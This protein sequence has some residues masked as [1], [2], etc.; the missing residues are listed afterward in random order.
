MLYA[1]FCQSEYFCI[2][3]SSAARCL[4][5]V[6]LFSFLVT[7]IW[8]E[9]IFHYTQTS[10]MYN[11]LHTLICTI[12]ASIRSA[13]L[14]LWLSAEWSIAFKGA[15]WDRDVCAV[16]LGT[17]SPLRWRNSGRT[18]D[19]PCLHFDWPWVTY[20]SPHSY[21]TTFIDCRKSLSC[22]TWRHLCNPG[23][24]AVGLCVFVE[25]VRSWRKERLKIVE[26]GERSLRDSRGMDGRVL[27]VGITKDRFDGLAMSDTW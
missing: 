17:T 22:R 1:V 4:L 14:W 9:L 27:V 26:A 8:W 21:C 12:Y 25:L 2:V 24:G 3:C 23:S 11:H 6:E 19:R 5:V 7:L 10:D 15:G 13:F 18:N 20:F 16:P